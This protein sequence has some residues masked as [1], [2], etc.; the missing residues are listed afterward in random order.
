M[1]CRLCEQW[2]KEIVSLSRDTQVF[3]QWNCS[4]SSFF[5][6]LFEEMDLTVYF[7]TL[8]ILELVKKMYIFFFS[9]HEVTEI[10][11]SLNGAS[12]YPRAYSALSSMLGKNS[13]NPGDITVVSCPFLSLKPVQN[14]LLLF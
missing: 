5:I 13:L 9:G 4:K 7:N 1:T 11:L 6:T 10:T 2:Q 3:R 8:A 14:V 12:A